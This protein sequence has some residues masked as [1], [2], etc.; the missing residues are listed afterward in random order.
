MSVKY[1][2]GMVHLEMGKRLGNRVHLGKAEAIFAE[3]GAELDL[4]KVRELLQR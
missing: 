4:A 1:D 3:I 2:I